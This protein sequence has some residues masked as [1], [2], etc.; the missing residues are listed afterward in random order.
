MAVPALAHGS[1]EQPE[2]TPKFMEKASRWAR[3]FAQRYIVHDPQPGEEVLYEGIV[4]KK[5]MLRN[6]WNRRRVLLTPVGLYFYEDEDNDKP[7][8][9]VFPLSRVVELWHAGNSGRFEILCQRK[10]GPGQRKVEFNTSV[11]RAMSIREG[12]ERALDHM[13]L[14]SA[15]ELGGSHISHPDKDHESVRS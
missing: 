15:I 9:E 8:T 11:V 6:K 10:F 13:R 3:T 4:L 12:F 1:A 5:A 7:P 14:E 2:F